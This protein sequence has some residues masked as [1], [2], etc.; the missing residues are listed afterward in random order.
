MNELNLSAVGMDQLTSSSVANAMPVS[1]NHLGLTASP[2]HNALTTPGLPV[3]IPN[4]GPSIS[5]LPSALSVMLPMGIGERGVMCGLPERNYSLP[6]PPYPHLESSYFRHILPG[7]LSYL[8]DRPPPQYIH[9]SSLNVDGSGGLSVSN[10]SQSLDPYQSGGSVGLE[11]GMV[12]LDRTVGGHAGQSLHPSDGH[13]VALDAGISMDNVSRVNSPITSDRITEE[14]TIDGVTR[15]HSQIS[16][17]SRSH[18][19]LTVDAN[20]PPDAVG[21]S[22]VLPL[23][24]ASL[25]LPVV[26]ESE[27]HMGSR[28]AITENSL[29]DAIHNVALNSN[30]VSVALSTSHQLSSLTSVSLHGGAMSLEPVT[31][32]SITQEVSLTG[33]HV[34]AGNLT[35]VP[36]SLQIDSNSNK[37]NIATLFTI[38]CTLCNRAY[39]SECP[40]HGPVTFI[41]DNP[42]ESRAR[43]SLPK[44]LVL[45]QSVTGADVGVWT[46][47]NIPVRTCF[48]PLIGQESQSLEVAGWTDKSAN[49]IWK[50]YDNNV[51]E[52]CIITTDENECNWMMF[53]RKARNPEEQ[54]LEA[55]PHNGKIYFCTSQDI[56]AQEELLFYYSRDYAQQMGVPEQPEML[57]CHCGK[58]CSSYA[59]FKAHLTSHVNSHLPSE[60]LSSEDT[61]QALT[62][63]KE[64][65][66]KCS[67]CPRSF[68][69]SSKLN[70]HYMGHMGMKPHKCEFCSKAFS[71]PSNLRTHLRIHTGQKNHRCS[72]CDKLFTQKSHLASHMVTHT[73][74]KNLKCDF[75]EK[76]FM[77]RQDLKQHMLT[78][79]RERQIKC[80]KWEKHFCRTNQLKKHLNSHEGK[81]DYVCEKCS[82]A[83]LTKY[84]LT[85]HLKIC[86]GPTMAPLTD[87]DEEDEDSEEEE[88]LNSDCN[89]FNTDGNLAHT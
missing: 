54:N 3:A 35:F 4:I 60:T 59:E 41:P 24:S 86:K 17:V 61:S 66:W 16:S 75:C 15:E 53:V 63:S 5:S 22:G 18:E 11:T 79:T 27:H 67:V 68:S 38:W 23:H 78:H 21:H 29:G 44:Q 34:D 83:F 42:I 32:S 50:M 70:V 47:E 76:M 74:E 51:M 8:A 82:N 71:D 80:P 87:A 89:V 36:S 62:P 69:S 26:M 30:P 85:R 13:E 58:E 25:E 33:G 65:K 40:E 88:L 1:G 43:L 46:Q 55:Y 81:R 39:P 49:H 19:S 10:N 84:H 14:L 73:G 12:S 57:L 6:P 31:V 7:I 9:P 77:R 72:L 52:F 2:P 20:L 56:P 37:E 64:R 45:R 28:S 48:G